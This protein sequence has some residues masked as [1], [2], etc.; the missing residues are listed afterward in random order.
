MSAKYERPI[1]DSY[2]VQPG[3]LLAGEYPE[4]LQEEKAQQK[5]CQLLRAGVLFFLDLTEEGE[6]ELKPYAPLLHKV[7]IAFFDEPTADLDDHRRDN[8][9]EQILNVKGFS[10]LFVISHDDSFEQD[11]NERS[12]CPI[13]AKPRREVQSSATLQHR[14]KA[15]PVVSAADGRYIILPGPS[16][17]HTG[18][19]ANL[20]WATIRCAP[21]QRRKLNA[22]RPNQKP[23]E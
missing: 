2:W 22:L 14:G 3:R 8:L 12:R 18:L 21:N 5:L 13:T 16:Y 6:Y 4:A 10:Q 11:T 9:A 23:F 20:I 17:Y 19:T 1:P 15:A 7:D